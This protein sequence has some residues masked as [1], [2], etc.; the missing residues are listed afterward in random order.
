LAKVIEK[1]PL[2]TAYKMDEA[3]VVGAVIS[4]ARAGNK[5][6][7]KLLEA[8]PSLQEP[9]KLYFTKELFGQDVAPTD[10]VIKTFLKNNEIPLKQLG[11]YKDFKDLRTAQ[12]TAKDAV[13][14]AKDFEKGYKEGEKIAGAAAKAAKGEQD[15]LISMSQTAQQRL[16]ETMQI[17]E[18]IEKMLSRSETR[19]KPAEVKLKQR[20][21]AVEKTMEQINGVEKEYNS[22]VN[23]LPK[24]KAKEIPGAIES[25]AEKMLKQGYITQAERNSFVDAARKNA[26]QLKDAATARKWVLGAV[27]I[28]GVPQ[29]ASKLT[30]MGDVPKYYR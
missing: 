4:K 18:P 22:L 13:E 21:G 28:L 20:L 19:A 3:A 10:A 5:V 7:E 26:E 27:A 25:A 6:F 24:M 9:A 11:L 30:P 29:L 23:D 2:S 15:R 8:N 14:T 12:R 17:A 1:D 16:A